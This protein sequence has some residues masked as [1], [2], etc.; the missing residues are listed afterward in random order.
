MRELS[1]ISK[2]GLTTLPSR[3]KDALG[4]EEGDYLEWRVVGNEVV[5]RVVKNPY[6][7]LRGRYNDP[8]LTYDAVEGK[9]DQIL[10]RDV[11]ASS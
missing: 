11:D 4:A 10:R 1:K 5:V 8:K 9:A 6:K 2:K 3:I 7:F